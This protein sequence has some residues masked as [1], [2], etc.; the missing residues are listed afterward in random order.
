MNRNRL[1]F[2]LI[3]DSVPVSK[4]MKKTKTKHFVCF[5][6]KTST[7]LKVKSNTKN[8]EKIDLL[9][10]VFLGALMRG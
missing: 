9:P 10:L 6:I 2:M 5:I 3:K 4:M 1:C 7:T 8:F